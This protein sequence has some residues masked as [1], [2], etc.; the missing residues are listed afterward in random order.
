[1]TPLVSILIP[2]LDR[3]RYLREAIEAARAQTYRN[4]EVLVF[5]NGTQEETRAVVELAAAQDPRVICRRHPRNLGMSANFNALADAARGEF[6]V[7]IG[8]D[9]RLLPELIMGARHGEFLEYHTSADNFD[10]VCPEALAESLSTILAVTDSLEQDR[11][12]LNRKPKGEPHLCRYDLT[13]SARNEKERRMD[14]LALRGVVNLSDGEH[15]LLEIA[16][17]ANLPLGVK[18][19]RHVALRG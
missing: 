4:L 15:S 3:P 18:K 6:V 5:D 1:M 14:E 17:H 16:D 13:K 8:D 12:Y 19:M 9:G 7:A 10:F 2:T 11:T